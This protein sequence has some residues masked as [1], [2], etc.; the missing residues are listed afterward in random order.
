MRN[1]DCYFLC[2]EHFPPFHVCIFFSVSLLWQSSVRACQVRFRT[3]FCNSAKKNVSG[4]LAGVVLNL[5]LTLG[6]IVILTILNFP[7]HENEM[8]SHILMSSLI[9][10]S[11]DL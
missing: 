2:H 8:S 10:F 9:S 6:S 5:Q 3:D 11:K 4:I 1:N 7:V